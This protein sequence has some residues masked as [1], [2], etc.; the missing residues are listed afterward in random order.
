[1]SGSN[2]NFKDNL[3]IDNNKALKWLDTN[4]NRNNILVLDTSGNINLN[5]GITT[6]SDLFL[7]SN[8]ISNSN[9]FINVNQ[10]S[11]GNYTLIGTKLG[12]NISDTSNIA[13]TLTLSKNSWIGLN[14]TQGS[15]NGYLGISPSSNLTNTSGSRIVLYGNDTSTSSGSVNLYAGNVTNGN[16]NIYSGND[17]LIVQVLNSGV[18]NFTPNGNTVRMSVSDLNTTVTNPLILTNTSESYSPS[19]GALQINGGIGINGNTFIQGTLSINSVSG[20]INFNN[21]TSSSSYSTG[22]LFISGGFGIECSTPASSQT[23]GGGL[24]VAG[25]L[26][27]GQNAMLGGNITIYDSSES[28]S[29]LTGSIIG[30]G[31][32]GLNGKI[33]LRSDASPQINIIPVSNNNETSIF[34][35]SKNNYITTGSWIIGHNSN[36]VGNGNFG[37]YSSNNGIYIMLDGSNNVINLNKYT[38][39]LNTIKYT[40]NITNDLIVFNNINNNYGW[41]LGKLIG[42]NNDLHISRFN[43]SGTFISYTLIS[44]YNNG[45]I[46]ITSTNN[47][48][49]TTT[50]GALTV[51]GGASIANDVYIG[52]NVYGGNINFTGNLISQS[53]G[54]LNTFS[55]LT[56]TATDQSIN[57]STGCLIT[58]GGITIQCNTNASSYTD[59]GSFLTPGGASIGQDLYVGGTIITPNVSTNS[60]K[61]T[62]AT[63]SNILITNISTTTLTTTLISTTNLLTT[64]ISTSS[65]TTTLI[66]TTNL[67]TTNISSGNASIGNINSVIGTFGTLAVQNMTVGVN[68]VSTN[69]F[70]SARI[71][72]ANLAGSN[73]TIQNLTSNFISTA[74]LILSSASFGNLCINSSGSLNINTNVSISNGNINLTGGSITINNG[75]LNLNNPNSIIQVSNNLSLLGTFIGINT[76]SQVYNFD[77]TGSLRSDNNVSINDTVN[78]ITNTVG[79]INLS[80]D[81]ALSNSTRNTIIFSQ[82]GISVPSINN[83]SI[84]TKIVLYPSISGSLTDIAFGVENSNMWQS[85]PSSSFGFKWYQGTNLTL[86]ITT[87]SNLLLTTTTNATNSSTGSF[88]TFGGIGINSLTNSSNITSG[89]ALTIAG[90]AAIRKDLYIGGS[91]F[92][93]SSASSTINNLLIN[94]TSNSIGIGSGGNL[95]ILGGTSISKDTYIGTTLAIGN[96]TLSPNKTLEISPITYSAS[97]DGGLRIS[98]KN[99]ISNNDPSYRYIDL[100][101]KSDSSSNFRGAIC[102]TSS[103]GIP[104]E[105]EYMSFDQ[106]GT[107]SVNPVVNFK[108]GTA[109]TFSSIGSL[110]LSGGLSINC[111]TNATDVSSGGALTIAGGAAI[112]G[113]LYVGGSIYYSNAAQASSTFAY[114]TLTATDE[115]INIGSGA[116]IVFGGV[117]IQTNANATSATSGGGLTIAGGAGIGGS[118]YVGG[119]SYLPNVNSTTISATN[120]ILT[121]S[122][123]TNFVSNFNT[124]GNVIFTKNNNLGVNNVNPLYTLDILGTVNI[125]NTV[126]SDNSTSGA[127]LINGGVSIS[128]TSNATSTTS[129][130]AL[131]IAGGMSVSKD[132]YVGGTVVSS[133]D[134]R[135]KTNLRPIENILDKIDN[136]RTVK[137]NNKDDSDKIDHFGF[138]AQDFE[139][140][141]PELLKSEKST[142]NNF[143]FDSY[144]ALD[145]SRVTVLLM[146]CIKELKE[147]IKELKIQIK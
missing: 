52:G 4:G 3:T 40:S 19:T 42:N 128:K 103:G 45:N 67:L 26:A 10:N 145:Y 25:G 120:T 78:S 131:T 17:N 63:I 76:T 136:I 83:R 68:L 89:G 75:S 58:F 30:Y 137:Y 39:A 95:T 88:V 73:G 115:S 32:M 91:I 70:G 108:N 22:T 106:D 12:V 38:N 110:V 116:L 86:S 47:S 142:E 69:I 130:G 36:S 23:A 85:V 79:A 28:V 80:G 18:T 53:S 107:I 133:S 129:G 113:D 77:I 146:K 55:Y 114:L 100:R 98:T 124:I 50:G 2:R 27:L 11:N 60:L 90:G 94:S 56:L 66:S 7:N 61:V 141:F 41:S 51:N 147:E 48:S 143:V 35:G 8:N 121:N 29:S 74:N 111:F 127:F 140:D 134:I 71:S 43:T 96:S 102:G 57:L 15:N 84:G 82:S 81:I 105:Y 37:M 112:S 99:A 59:G 21:S 13:S 132:I 117:S 9:T 123:I 125:N 126:V 135:L 97:Q 101:L 65:L 14:T 44:D 138:L 62:D 6:Q 93:A 92:Q 72:S 122:T 87:T 64:N 119:T 144:Y 46:T 118:L 49:N 1:M 20:N 109:S 24:S 31:G 33:F 16:V 34:F 5:S 54:D 139:N 104:S